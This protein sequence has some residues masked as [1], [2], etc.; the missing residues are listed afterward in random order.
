LLA[1]AHGSACGSCE[2]GIN[3]PSA[4]ATAEHAS[5]AHR[6]FGIATAATA[7]TGWMPATP[8]MTLNKKHQQFYFY[9]GHGVGP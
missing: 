8:A 2:V 3:A 1:H 9:V 6:Q 5:E 7:T 4:W